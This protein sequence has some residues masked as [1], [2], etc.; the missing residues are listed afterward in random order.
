MCRFAARVLLLLV[1][2]SLNV[3]TVF[4]FQN[5]PLNGTCAVNDK[6]AT[7]SELSADNPFAAP[8]KLA[9]QAPPFD[10]IRVEHYLSAY[11]AGIKKQLNL[12]LL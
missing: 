2:V 3:G 8:S 5:I 9:L 10:V 1:V 11:M 12:K 7:P 4:G 6:P